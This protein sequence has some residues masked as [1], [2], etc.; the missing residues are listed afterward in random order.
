MNSTPV[1][2]SSLDIDIES[3]LAEGDAEKYDHNI[4]FSGEAIGLK[5][6]ENE[7]GFET[8]AKTGGLVSPADKRSIQNIDKLRIT[9]PDCASL[10]NASFFIGIIKPWWQAQLEGQIETYRFNNTRSLASLVFKSVAESSQQNLQRRFAGDISQ[11]I[12]LIISDHRSHEDVYAFKQSLEKAQRDLAI[13]PYMSVHV[14]DTNKDGQLDP[15][16]L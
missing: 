13:W 2:P 6:F 11:S 14:P 1:A 4:A 12:E 16:A 7:S 9:I 3:L 5:L 10:V 8:N 15:A